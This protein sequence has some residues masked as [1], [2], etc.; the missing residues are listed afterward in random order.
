MAINLSSF[1]LDMQCH[2]RGESWLDPRGRGPHIYTRHLFGTRS[3]VR[4][5][6]FRSTWTYKH[7]LYNGWKHTPPQMPNEF[8]IH[9]ISPWTTEALPKASAIGIVMGIVYG[10]HSART[11]R[12]ASRGSNVTSA[13]LKVLSPNLVILSRDLQLGS[14]HATSASVDIQSFGWVAL[15]FAANSGIIAPATTICIEGISDDSLNMPYS[16]NE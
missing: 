8:T 11:F 13:W 7:P 16:P 14:G 6:L 4:P 5:N 12:Y 3:N 9:L 10:A 1:L 2:H 15:C